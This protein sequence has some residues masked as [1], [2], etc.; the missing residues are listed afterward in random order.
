VGENCQKKGSGRYK[1]QYPVEPSV[2]TFHAL[3]FAAK[4]IDFPFALLKSYPKM[5]V[6]HARDGTR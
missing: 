4:L 5:K 1:K 3:G 6:R 2:F